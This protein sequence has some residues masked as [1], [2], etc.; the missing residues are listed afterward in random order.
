MINVR[1][2]PEPSAAGRYCVVFNDSVLVSGDIVC[3]GN[4][5]PDG[6]FNTDFHSENG[7]MIEGWSGRTIAQVLSSLMGTFSNKDVTISFWRLDGPPHA[8][9]K[10]KAYEPSL[11]ATPVPLP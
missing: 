10:K 11:W 5:D 7:F 1:Y 9:R 2:I 8:V 6:E 4:A 3:Y